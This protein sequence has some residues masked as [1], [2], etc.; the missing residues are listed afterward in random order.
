ML[1]FTFNIR[2]KIFNYYTGFSFFIFI[3]VSE[4]AHD[5]NEIINHEKIHFYQQLEM[6]FIFHWLFYLSFYLVYRV[7]GMDHHKAY[8]R[9][10]FEKEAYDHEAVKEYLRKRKPYSWVKYW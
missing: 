3:W 10:P 5:K 7:K 9:I 6:L 1:P 8:Y 4:Q 2:S